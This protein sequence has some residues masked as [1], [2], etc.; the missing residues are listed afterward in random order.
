MRFPSL[1][2]ERYDPIHGETRPDHHG[3][4]Y[5]PEN[6][7]LLQG[8][9]RSQG[10]TETFCAQSLMQLV[11]WDATTSGASL[12]TLEGSTYLL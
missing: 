12:A 8:R 10:F 5:N 3:R 11:P 6:E 7:S 1:P 4:D 2:D 9:A